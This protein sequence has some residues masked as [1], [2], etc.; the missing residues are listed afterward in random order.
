MVAS[1]EWFEAC[2]LTLDDSSL[3]PR[4]VVRRFPGRT[5]FGI[6]FESFLGLVRFDRRPTLDVLIMVDNIQGHGRWK[7]SYEVA[8]ERTRGDDPFP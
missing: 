3:C 2:L 1:E 5:F 8:P 4:A 6:I 7:K